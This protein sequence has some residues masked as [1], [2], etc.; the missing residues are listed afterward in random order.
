MPR[1]ASA[2]SS[3]SYSAAARAPSPSLRC[4]FTESSWRRWG[5]AMRRLEPRRR[6]REVALLVGGDAAR[7]G[8]SASAASA[9]LTLAAAQPLE[10]LGRHA[11]RLRHLRLKQLR[12]RHRP[13]VAVVGA[14][15]V[16]VVVHRELGRDLR[17]C[18]GARRRQPPPPAT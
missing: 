2:L 6:A 1:E 18:L 5:A 17:R 15:A 16:A 11:S 13:V 9:S 7:A 8:S 14:G 4:M 10:Q 12:L 3:A